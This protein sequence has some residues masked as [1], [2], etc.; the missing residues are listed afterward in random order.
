MELFR[1][2]NS[3][4]ERPPSRQKA[5]LISLLL[6]CEL[7]ETVQKMWRRYLSPELLDQMEKL[8]DHLE[9]SLAVGQFSHLC[10]LGLCNNIHI[11]HAFCAVHGC[12]LVT[13]SSTVS[14]MKYFVK[15]KRYSVLRS[16]R[17]AIF[18]RATLCVE[19][20]LATATCPSVCLSVCYSRYCIKTERAS[21]MISLPSNSPMI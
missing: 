8:P 15:A 1:D 11:T 3:L 17:N 10:V 13:F 18:T 21:V 5:K 2:I 6:D 12:W 16:A 7:V 9:T 19:R 4:A 20:V 14:Q